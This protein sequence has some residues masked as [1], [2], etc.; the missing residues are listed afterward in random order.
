MREAIENG[1]SAV[2]RVYHDDN[3]EFTHRCTGSL[4]VSPESIRFESDDNR[5]T[6]ETST[7]NVDRLKF[8]RENTREWK[9]RSIFKVFLKIGAEKARFRFAP[10]SGAEAETQLVGRFI[11]ESK[12]ETAST[13][14][15]ALFP[16][17]Y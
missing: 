17:I 10:I 12:A 7:G 3:G 6:F 8:D 5:H 16:I 11:N 1:G 4:Y 14:T 13:A 15:A 2:F 9:N